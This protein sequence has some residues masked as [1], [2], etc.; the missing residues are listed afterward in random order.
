MYNVHI[1]AQLLYIVPI[2][3]FIHKAQ[4]RAS[5]FLCLKLCIDF[6]LLNNKL[7]QRVSDLKQHKIIILQFLW[8]R[9]LPKYPFT[10]YFLRMS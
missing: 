2:H 8:P 1:N 3:V 7:S 5:T 4:Y 10:G 6:L 9:H